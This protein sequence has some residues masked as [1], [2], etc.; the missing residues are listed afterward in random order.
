MKTVRLLLIVTFAVVVA[1]AFM[2][3]CGKAAKVKDAYIEEA[4][5]TI[6]DYTTKIDDL[7]VKA[8]ALPSPAKETAIA[9][10]D[11]VKAKLEEGK[12]KLEELKGAEASKWA[13]LMTELK[14]ILAD[15]V[16]LYDEAKTA[17]EG[18]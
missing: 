6:D 4:Q 10:I 5:A 2:A 9:K 12:A 18:G 3:G 7:V 16:K 1:A 14:T 17:V 8:E 15:L 11:E 13:A